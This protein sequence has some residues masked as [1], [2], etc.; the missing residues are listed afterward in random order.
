[1][2]EEEENLDLGMQ[3]FSITNNGLGSGG[4]S[5]VIEGQGFPTDA[6]VFFGEASPRMYWSSIRRPLR[7]THHPVHRES[8]MSACWT[9]RKPG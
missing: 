4:E 5:V 7:S 8:W 2:I 9:N 6:Q 1:M 3:I